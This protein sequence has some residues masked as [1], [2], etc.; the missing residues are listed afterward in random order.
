MQNTYKIEIENCDAR[1]H[2]QNEEGAPYDQ[3]SMQDIYYSP[4]FPKS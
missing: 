3:H 4:R 2:Q 1:E